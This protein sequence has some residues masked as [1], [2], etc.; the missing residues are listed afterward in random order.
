MT[1]QSV[2][3]KWRSIV[4]AY[5]GGSSFATF[6]SCLSLYETSPWMGRRSTSGF[7][8]MNL[9]CLSVHGSN[10]CLTV[11]LVRKSQDRPHRL[12]PTS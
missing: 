4:P 6:V 5:F 1:N 9:C 2:D 10:S 8:R 7:L 12:W 11:R 3:I